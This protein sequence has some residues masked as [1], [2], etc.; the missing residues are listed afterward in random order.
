MRCS[1]SAFQSFEDWL[2]Q[3]PPPSSSSRQVVTVH[4][5]DTPPPSS[6]PS[7]AATYVGD[8]QFHPVNILF[9]PPI[10]LTSFFFGSLIDPSNAAAHPVLY[11]M[12]TDL[13]TVSL[14]FMNGNVVTNR[15]QMSNEDCT[16]T[17]QGMIIDAIGED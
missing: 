11:I 17:D 9:L 15:V 6:G 3:T 5:Q 1:K 12:L 13:V 14:N 4:I 16:E 8:L 2:Q 10:L 7:F